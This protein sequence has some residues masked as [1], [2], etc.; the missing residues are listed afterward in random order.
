MVPGDIEERQRVADLD[1]SF[2]TAYDDIADLQALR[3]QDVAFFA[4][5][6]VQKGNVG[7]TVRIVFD[8]SHFSRDI[9]L[10]TFEIDDTILSLVAA[11]LMTDRGLTGVVAAGMLV[12]FDNQRAMGLIRRNLFKGGH[13][14]AASRRR[15]RIKAL[16][17]MF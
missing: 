6:I 2:G 15:I 3:S 13:S 1:I 11:A 12:Q 16:I 17:A 10:R 4:V 7:R 9:V 14:H 5:S 8:R